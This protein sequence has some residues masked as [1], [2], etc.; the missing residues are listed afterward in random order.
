[1]MEAVGDRL[2]LGMPYKVKFDP[3]LVNAIE[4]YVNDGT[5]PCGFLYAILTNNFKE[6]FA[7]GDYNNRSL[8]LTWYTC[9]QNEIPYHAQGDKFKVDGWV[10]AGGLNHFDEARRLEK[11]YRYKAAKQIVE[12][13]EMEIVE[14]YEMEGE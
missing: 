6:A 11:E 7:I 2:I 4:N 9:V 3:A 10:A 5:P 8:M 14:D 12:D 13:Y 1:M